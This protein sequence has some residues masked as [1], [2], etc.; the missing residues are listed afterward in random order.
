MMAL[1]LLVFA[2]DTT[3]FIVQRPGEGRETGDDPRFSDERVVERQF[4]RTGP[5][6]GAGHTNVALSDVIALCG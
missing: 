4:R 3:S 6:V 2:L 5:G 1:G